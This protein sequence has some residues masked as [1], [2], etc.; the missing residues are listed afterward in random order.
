MAG[1]PV[2]RVSD[3]VGHGSAKCSEIVQGSSKTKCEGQWVARPGD[4]NPHGSSKVKT[5]S[6]RVLEGGKPLSRVDDKAQ[7]PGSK[8]LKGARKTLV[9]GPETEKA[10]KGGSARTSGGAQATMAGNPMAAM[11]GGNPMAAAMGMMGG[12]PLGAAMGMMGGMMG[13]NPMGMLS[14]MMGP[15]MGM[16]GP[17]GGL[18]GP[19]MGMVQ[20][21]PGALMGLASAAMPML[22]NGM[23]GMLGPAMAGLGGQMLQGAASIATQA[24]AG[25]GG[26]GAASI[27]GGLAGNL[28]SGGGVSALSH[29]GSS[30]MQAG[31]SQVMGQLAVG[32]GGPAASPMQF[33]TSL[34]STM[35]PA[36][37]ARDLPPVALPAPEGG[38]TAEQLLAADAA[39]RAH[40]EN[41]EVFTRLLADADRHG[42][43][44]PPTPELSYATIPDDQLEAVVAKGLEG[45]A[46]SR[47]AGAGEGAIVFGH[48]AP[49]QANGVTLVIPTER[50]V[51]LGGTP[52]AALGG[53][54]PTIAFPPDAGGIPFQEFAVASAVPR[55]YVEPIY[56]PPGWEGGVGTTPPAEL[57]PNA[58][59]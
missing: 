27:L 7:C 6:S 59:A 29:L 48:G 23:S 36:L 22:M 15:L 44:A 14:G 31:V 57:R 47:G 16:M 20:G 24:L 49:T 30:A 58:V 34:A 1:K 38:P 5:G 18:I 10:K 52:Q 17:V 42:A 12:N 8:I 35:G 55:G 26:Q 4:P 50:L 41:D 2:A 25:G 39:N 45:E 43:Y 3:P 37:D 13:G 54:G 33:V 40:Y 11:M 21:G 19:L 9:G 56:T 32:G 51:E 53:V 46:I 28:A